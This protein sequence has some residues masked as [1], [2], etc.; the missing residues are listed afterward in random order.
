MKVEQDPNISTGQGAT[1]AMT[2]PP[3]PAASHQQRRERGRAA[4]R[5]AP[6][7]SHAE[8]APAPNRPDP[9]DLLEALAKDRLPELLPIRYARMMVSPFAFM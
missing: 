9:V 6:R 8:W 5:V 2:D 1:G 7:Y 3:Q 4:R